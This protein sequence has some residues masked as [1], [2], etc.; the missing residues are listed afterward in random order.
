MKQRIKW[1]EEVITNNLTQ[2][3]TRLDVNEEKDKKQDNTIEHNE[4]NASTDRNLLR[5]DID[6]VK[7]DLIP[8]IGSIIPWIP[9]PDGPDATLQQ[10]IPDGWQKCDGSQILSGPLINLRTPNLNGEGLFLR[11]GNDED[12]TD[13]QEDMVLDHTHIDNKHTHSDSGHSH[14]QDG[15]QHKAE[16]GYQF[17]TYNGGALEDTQL[18]LGAE[19]KV[20]KLEW[21]CIWGITNMVTPTIKSSKANIQSA[22]S[23]MSTV[24]SSYRKGKEN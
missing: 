16:N 18:Y 6:E 2:L 13:V 12:V 3:M 7:D 11:G 23:G 9:S 4:N 19:N 1:L 15:H 17:P 14:T 21:N 24:S 5:K 22:E 10:K 20:G 8:G